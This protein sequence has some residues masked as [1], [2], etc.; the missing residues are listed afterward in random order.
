MNT[1]PGLDQI[2]N[3]MECPF[4]NDGEGKRAGKKK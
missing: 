3:E 2:K 1:E 4:K